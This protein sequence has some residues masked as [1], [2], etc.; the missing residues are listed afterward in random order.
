MPDAALVG[1]PLKKQRPSM[2]YSAM[3]NFS[4]TQNLSAALDSVVSGDSVPAVK[5]AV[6]APKLTLAEEEEL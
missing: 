5:P 4:A 1:S 6:E 3:G 2:D